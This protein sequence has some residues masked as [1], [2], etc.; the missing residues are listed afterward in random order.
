M[1][2]CEWIGPDLTAVHVLPKLK[3]LFDELAFS[4]E[5]FSGPGSSGNRL[6][7]PQERIDEEVHIESRADLV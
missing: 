7:P 5:I 1:A 6:K 4:K 3:E 2:A